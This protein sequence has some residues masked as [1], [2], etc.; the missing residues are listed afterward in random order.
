MKFKI[1]K[2]K[3]LHLGMNNPTHQYVLGTDQ[4]ENGFAEKDLRILVDTELSMS[5]Q[6]VLVA[7]KANCILG[8]IKQSTASKLREVIPPLCSALVR[9]HL[10]YC[11]QCWAPQ[12][13]RD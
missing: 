11:V 5:Q 8:F 7:K 4:L 3:V 13:K 1:G 2:C 6:C 12:Y 9:V 10:E